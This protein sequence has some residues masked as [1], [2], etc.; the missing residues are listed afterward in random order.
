MA[1]ILQQIVA[2]KRLQVARDSA[3]IGLA[4]VRRLALAEPPGRDFFAA[5]T[6]PGP[7]INVIAEVKKA[8][9][10][11]GLI[12]PDFDPV[13]IAR[14][15][16]AGGAAAISCLTDEKYF[17]G[18]LRYIRMIRQ[19]IDLPVLRKE[20]VIDPYQVYEARAAGADAVLL[21][22]E[23]LENESLDR[24]HGLI[25]ELGM[26][27]LIEIHDPQNLARTLKIAGGDRP[28]AARPFLLGIINRDL[29]AMKTDLDH[30]LR[31][32]DRVPDRSILVSESG[33]KTHA[34]VA[35]LKAAGIPA[36]LVGEHLMRQPDVEAALR[37]M[38]EGK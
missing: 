4:E 18:D 31:L 16:K 26:T 35:R 11:A 24:L 14:A 8:S 3:R 37:G 27:A 34:D 15:Y 12:R 17:Q 28:G 19:A 22:A 13:A 5:V 25:V 38:I 2:D 23:C 9:P 36:V 29:K 33:I 21:I 6:R 30:T 1:D 10:S 7:R 32:L 20:F